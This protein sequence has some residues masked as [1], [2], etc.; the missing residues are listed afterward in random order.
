MELYGDGKYSYG[1]SIGNYYVENG[2]LLLE[3]TTAG[4]LSQVFKIE[5]VNG[6]KCL[7]DEFGAIFFD[8]IDSA[9]LY[10]D[11]IMYENQVAEEREQEQSK[12]ALNNLIDY[13]PGTWIDESLGGEYRIVIHE[14]GIYERY[15]MGS[16]AR[17]GT[18]NITE[19]NSDYAEEE[20]LIEMTYPNG[21]SHF[22]DVKASHFINDAAINEYFSN[23]Y[24]ELESFD[25]YI[26]VY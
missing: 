13:F 25:E 19:K 7:I 12:I 2:E 5:K 17:T 20:L 15:K 24:F 3:P 18:W 6:E 10:Y 1:D 9:I 8:N 4:I 26:K 21:G 16:V 23:N 14:N 22:L 11:E